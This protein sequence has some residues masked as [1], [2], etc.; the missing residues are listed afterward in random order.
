MPGL[1]PVTKLVPMPITAATGMDAATHAVEAYTDRWPNAGAEAQPKTIS[2]NV[3]L[4]L[5]L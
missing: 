3:R 1:A 4:D 5:V 2:P